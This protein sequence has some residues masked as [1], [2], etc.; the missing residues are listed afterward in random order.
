MAR[1]VAT[2]LGETLSPDGLDDRRGGTVVASS[3]LQ[4]SAIPRDGPR[5]EAIAMIFFVVVSPRAGAGQG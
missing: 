5:Q 3:R 2:H 1:R 4:S